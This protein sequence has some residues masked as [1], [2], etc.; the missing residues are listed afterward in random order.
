[1]MCWDVFSVGV[2]KCNLDV[3]KLP[4]YV[5]PLLHRTTR[6]VYFCT[7]IDYLNYAPTLCGFYC[8]VLLLLCYIVILHGPTLV[9]LYRSAQCF[10]TTTQLFCCLLWC[11]HRCVLSLFAVKHQPNNN[12]CLTGIIHLG[13]H[14]FQSKTDV[15]VHL[16]C[17][18]IVLWLHCLVL[19]VDN[20]HLQGSCLK[21]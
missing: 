21:E 6:T 10:C 16:N 3:A 19:C 8:M 17:W 15:F 4:P 9:S 1:M 5:S 20:S 2:S 12:A 18:Y 7:V 11:H 14:L 13:L